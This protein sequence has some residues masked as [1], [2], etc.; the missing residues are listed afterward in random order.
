MTLVSPGADV[1]AADINF[2]ADRTIDKPIGRIL[3]S[4]A[5]SFASNTIVA[6][7][8]GAEDYDTHGFHDVATNTSRIT[9]TAGWAGYY[10]LDATLIYATRSD[11]LVVDAWWRKNGVTNIPPGGRRSETTGS[12]ASH[13]AIHAHARIF[14]DPALGDYVELMG[15]QTNTAAA[16]ALTAFVTPYITT[17]EWAFSRR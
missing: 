7:L 6:C 17:M 15:V 13:Q 12:V 14:L 3:A 9:P 10:D 16:A 1:D 8:M 11:Y 4:A 2:M 5:Q